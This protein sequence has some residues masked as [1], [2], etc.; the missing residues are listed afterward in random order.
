[1]KKRNKNI[2]WHIINEDYKTKK[3]EQ[4][5]RFDVS[6]KAIQLTE[7]QQQD[8]SVAEQLRKMHDPFVVTMEPEWLQQTDEL[9]QTKQQDSCESMN[10]LDVSELYESYQKIKTEEQELIDCK[11]DLQSME[12]D[13]REKLSKEIGKKKKAIE[14]LQLEISAL[15]NTCRVISQELQPTTE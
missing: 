9:N 8:A 15:Q 3:Q 12:Q 5:Q 13:L 11:Q 6:G 10:S 14:A 7:P 1:M 2:F 4:N